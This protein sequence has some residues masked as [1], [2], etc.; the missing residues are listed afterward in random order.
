M[1]GGRVRTHN[2]QTTDGKIFVTFI[3]LIIRTYILGKLA[4][5]IASN[6][7]SFKKAINKLENIIIIQSNGTYRFAK[8]LTKQQKEILAPFNAEVEISASLESCLR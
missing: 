8:A 5:Y 3:A 1:R 6:S 4:K 7:S 2:E